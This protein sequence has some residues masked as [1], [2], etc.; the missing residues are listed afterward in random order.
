MTRSARKLVLARLRTRFAVFTLLL[1]LSEAGAIPQGPRIDGLAKKNCF[2]F[3]W[4][5]SAHALHIAT[6]RR[7]GRYSLNAVITCDWD[8]RIISVVQGCTGAAPDSFAQT[9]ANW[10]KYP[11][12]FFSDGEDLLGD[13]GMKYTD[14]VL[15][16]YKGPESTT[17]NRRKYNYQVACLRVR[18]EH[19]IGI[20]KGR[21]C[22][23]KELRPGIGSD[24]AFAHATEWI[25]ACCV[26]LNIYKAE[27]DGALERVQEDEGPP[28]TL[29]SLGSGVLGAREAV[30][31]RVCAF[32]RANGSFLAERQP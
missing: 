9:R 7:K 3:L 11:S 21:F 5:V 15:G 31:E 18:S 32:M 28:S 4:A 13:K 6:M 30:Q 25:L 17:P 16:P 10:H 24:K 26:L 23:L 8:D 12:S 27:N 1:A 14:R 19:T 2:R 20:L 29:E 22:S